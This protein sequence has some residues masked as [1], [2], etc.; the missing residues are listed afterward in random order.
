MSPRSE[1]RAAHFAIMS[2]A[3]RAMRECRNAASSWQ[4]RIFAEN[5]P[6]SAKAV[7][8]KVDSAAENGAGARGVRERRQSMKPRYEK[9]RIALIR[10]QAGAGAL[11]AARHNP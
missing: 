7:D 8:V 1:N 2:Q 4:C 5:Q 10:S 11:R 3:S 6:L 9:H